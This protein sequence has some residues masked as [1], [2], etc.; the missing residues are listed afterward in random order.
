MAEQHGTI[1][2]YSHAGA[3]SSTAL[4]PTRLRAVLDIINFSAAPSVRIA[5]ILY[6]IYRN[7]NPCAS[8]FA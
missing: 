2:D 5:Q 3:G 6:N 7:E 8:L 4:L 1:H